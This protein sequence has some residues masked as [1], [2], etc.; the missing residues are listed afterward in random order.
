M[1]MRLPIL[2]G[3][4]LF[5]ASGTLAYASDE[6]PSGN[7]IVTISSPMMGSGPDRQYDSFE[8]KFCR[9]DGSDAETVHIWPYAWLSR[10]KDDFVGPDE[11]GMVIVRP[12]APGDWGVCS[13]FVSSVLGMDFTPS[14]SQFDQLVSPKNFFI[15]FNISAG[16][17]TYIGDF[18]AVPTTVKNLFGMGV[19]GGPR[20]IV[21]DK[22]T[23]DVPVAQQKNPNLGP[24]DVSVFDVDRLADPAFATHDDTLK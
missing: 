5:L 23:R 17:A 9:Q 21:T 12:L 13:Y 22:S 2:I 18:L 1:K 3:L 4:S 14:G 7:V 11:A 6:G 24:V 20:W 10:D 8:L 16:R 15:P 19:Q